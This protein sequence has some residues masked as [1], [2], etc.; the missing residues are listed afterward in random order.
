MQPDG[1]FVLYDENRHALWSTGTW[2]HPGAWFFFQP[3]GNLVAYTG[4]NQF[5]PSGPIWQ[6]GTYGK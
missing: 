5:D 6:S 4:G 2:G 1:N 3:D